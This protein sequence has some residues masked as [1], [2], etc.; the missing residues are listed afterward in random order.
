[1]ID[2]DLLAILA[3]PKCKGPI[4]YQEKLEGLSCEACMLLYEIRDGIPVMLIEE[5]R[6]ITASELE[7]GA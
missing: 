3:C 2:Q 1:M 6:A 7:E 5:A 4:K